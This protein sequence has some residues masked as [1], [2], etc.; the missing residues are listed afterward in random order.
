MSE[1]LKTVNLS[2]GYGAKVILEDVNIN[3]EKGKVYTLIGPNGCGKSTLLKTI[4]NQLSS[5]KGTIIIDGISIKEISRNN[6]AKKMSMVMTKRGS[7]PFVTCEEFVAMGRYPYTDFFGKLSKEDKQKVDMAFDFIG[8]RELINQEFDSLSDGQ[9]QRI[10]IARAI[11]QEGEIL[12]LDEPTSFLDIKYKLEIIR[13]LKRLA[14]DRNVAVILSIHE[15]ELAR[16]VSDVVITIKDNHV[17]RV[18]T[19]QEVFSKGYIQKLYNIA[20]EDLDEETGM[21]KMPIRF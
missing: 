21:I 15:L 16:A 6:L 11:A 12:V 14:R 2:A 1:A 10:I 19:P 17:G 4:L 5:I 9:K 13:C 18:G 8:A 7:V 20:L 3:I